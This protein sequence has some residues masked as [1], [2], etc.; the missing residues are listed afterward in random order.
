MAKGNPFGNMGNIPG[1][2]NLMKQA[3]KM[4]AETERIQEELHNER[5]EV[6]SGGGMVTAVVTG[7]GELLEV[8]IDPQVVDPEDVE[9]LQDL[10]VSAVREA[11]DKAN[12]TKQERLAELTGGMGLPGLF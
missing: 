7:A 10:I 1:L 5:V 3:Q 4:A 12:E 6:S 11:L 9:M 8:K 2:G